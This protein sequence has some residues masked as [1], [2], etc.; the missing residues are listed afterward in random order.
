MTVALSAHGVCFRVQKASVVP[1]LS[2]LTMTLE[3]KIIPILQMGAGW[4]SLESLLLTAVIP[5]APS[6]PS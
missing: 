6:F 5:L 1:T 3:W 4:L 2:D